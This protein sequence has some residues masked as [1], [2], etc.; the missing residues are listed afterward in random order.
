M[1]EKNI[2]AISTFITFSKPL[3]PPASTTAPPASECAMAPHDPRDGAARQRR[4]AEARR[5]RQRGADRDRPDDQIEREVDPDPPRQVRRPSLDRGH[6]A[7]ELPAR[8][9]FVEHA[10]EEG[11][12]RHH[13]QQLQAVRRRRH[14]RRHD[15]AGADAG[16]GDEQS[17]ADQRD[18]PGRGCG[19]VLRLNRLP[20]GAP[21]I[22]APN[23]IHRS[24]HRKSSGR[25]RHRARL[26]PARRRSAG[27]DGRA[28]PPERRPPVCQSNTTEIP[29]LRAACA[30]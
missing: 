16:R 18:D 8:D 27:V 22:Y 26:R 7:G 2:V 6:A 28:P 29:Y 1:I 21:L 25:C 30:C 5:A 19:G 13:P 15:V 10:L 4:D 3:K 24:R 17:G 9:A 20:P 23:D 14:R 11:G 12:Q